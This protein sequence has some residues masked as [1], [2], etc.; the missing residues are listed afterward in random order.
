[1]EAK[2]KHPRVIKI[3]IAEVHLQ[4]R[5]IRVECETQQGQVDLHLDVLSARNLAKEVLEALADLGNDDCRAAFEL[6]DENE[7][8]TAI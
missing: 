8:S 3:E 4:G 6:L 1:M 7:R 2:P 5:G